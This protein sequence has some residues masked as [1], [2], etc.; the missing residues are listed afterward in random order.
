LYLLYDV[1]KRRQLG[2][3]ATENEVIA[4]RA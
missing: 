3:Q 1:A 2:K 4:T